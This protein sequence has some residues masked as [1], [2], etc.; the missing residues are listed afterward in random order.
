VGVALVGDGDE[1]ECDADSETNG[2][3]GAGHPADRSPRV[4]AR[5]LDSCRRSAPED[6]GE[7][8][9]LQPFLDENLLVPG[10]AAVGL[11]VESVEPGVERERFTLELAGEGLP[12]AETFTS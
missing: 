10:Q 3:R 4:P 12:F 6:R 1:A 2:T 8:L 7:L 5:S 9:A 11:E